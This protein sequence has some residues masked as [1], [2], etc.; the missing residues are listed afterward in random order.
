MA[1]RLPLL[2]VLVAERQ[3]RSPRQLYAQRW[4]STPTIGRSPPVSMELSDIDLGVRLVSVLTNIPKERLA[5]GRLTEEQGV[6]VHR[7]VERLNRN[8]AQWADMRPSLPDPRESGDPETTNDA[9]RPVPG[10]ADNPQSS[11]RGLAELLVLEN[12]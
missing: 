3:R 5:V 1:R 8:R 10:R 11:R 9:A 2:E 7:A 12:R 6:L 4:T